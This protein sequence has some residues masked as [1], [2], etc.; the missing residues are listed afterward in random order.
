MFNRFYQRFGGYGMHGYGM[1]FMGI[2]WILLLIL[3]VLVIWK[4]FS[5]SQ[6]TN[7]TSNE[8]TA[9]ELLKKEFAKGNITEEEFE[10]KKRLLK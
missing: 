7:P 8:D 3:F 2:F 5:N 1:G 10:R 4:L 9:L 6:K